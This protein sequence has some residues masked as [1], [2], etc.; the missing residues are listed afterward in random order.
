MQPRRRGQ[1]QPLSGKRRLG[2]HRLQRRQVPVHRTGADPAP[3]GQDGLG[4]AQPGQQRGRK[5]DRRPHPPRLAAGQAAAGGLPAHHHIPA[6]PPGGTARGP[7]QR[8]A[9]LHVRKAGRP[10]QPHRPAAEQACRQKR[11]HAVLGRGDPHR[12]I[13]GP[14][15]PHLDHPAHSKTPRFAKDTLRYAKRGVCVRN[16]R[17]NGGGGIT[18]GVCRSK[19]ATPPAGRPTGRRPSPPKAS[20]GWC[21]RRRKRA[22]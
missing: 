17:P 14:S 5:E 11:Q 19:Y 22:G 2:A 10:P 18:C 21:R 6:V 12:P 7:Q 16:D 9:P 3:A 15:A 8:K 1:D 13:Q 4:A 20:S